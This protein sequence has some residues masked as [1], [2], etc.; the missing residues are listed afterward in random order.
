MFSKMDPQSQRGDLSRAFVFAVKYS[1]LLMIPASIMVMIFSRYLIILTFGSSYTFAPQYL[2]WLAALYLLTGIGYVI[3]GSFLNGTALTGTVLR[4]SILTL[5]IYLPLSP[6]LAWVWGPLGVLIAY[7]V[8]SAMSTVYGLSR[9]SV[10]FGA[11]PDLKASGRILLA[12]LGAAAPTITLIRLDAVGIDMSNLILGSLLFL[13]VYLTLAPVTGAV[14]KW[15]ISNLRSIFCRTRMVAWLANPIFDYETKLLS[16]MRRD[17]AY[18][19]TSDYNATNP[20][21]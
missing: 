11:R 15:D 20:I 14:D 13:M 10:L 5:A 16:F 3:L 18:G 6:V 12:S 17:S 2:A 9:A 19:D 4:M 8:A 21:R 7:I 1:S